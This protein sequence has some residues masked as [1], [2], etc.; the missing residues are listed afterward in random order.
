MSGDPQLLTMTAGGA[1]LAV[2]VPVLGSLVAEVD[3]NDMDL[4]T[5]CPS[6]TTRDLLNHVVGGATMFADA[7]GGAGLHDISGRMPDLVGD[8]PLGAFQEAA[9]RFAAAAADPEALERKFTLPWGTMD[10]ATVLRFLAFDLLVHSWDL[11]TTLGREV[12]VRDDL[13]VSVGA[14]AHRALDPWTRDG[15]NFGPP[16]EADPS[17][18][19]LEALVAFAGRTP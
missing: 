16:V 10:G 8:D 7:F 9:G 1:Q 6:W 14:F 13:V 5:P 11:A 12:E 19:P 15:V 17:A 18:T 2:I 4:S 3:R